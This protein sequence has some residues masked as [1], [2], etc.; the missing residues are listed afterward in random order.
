MNAPVFPN[1]Q[2]GDKVALLY[3]GGKVGS[4]FIIHVTPTQIAVDAHPGLRYRRDNGCVLGT[5]GCAEPWT[6][7][8]DVRLARFAAADRLQR[9]A[10][11]LHKSTSGWLT[12]VLPDNIDKANALAAAIEAYL[13][14]IIPPEK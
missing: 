1:P 14:P 3:R 11:M 7:E 8:H 6:D 12:P 13:P 5:A 9:A 4:T 2:K 10:H